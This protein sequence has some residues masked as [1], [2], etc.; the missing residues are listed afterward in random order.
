LAKLKLSP[1]AL[2]DTILRTWGSKRREQ[3]EYY[4]VVKTDLTEH[5]AF[6]EVSSESRMTVPHTEF[7]HSVPFTAE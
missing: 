5:D 1:S 4:V 3:L 2:I 6:V 7:P